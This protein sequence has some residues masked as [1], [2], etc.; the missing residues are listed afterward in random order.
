MKGEFSAKLV[1]YK[2]ESRN[3]GLGLGQMS[4]EALKLVCTDF[5]HKEWC[6]TCHAR[7]L[8][9]QWC[10]WHG[11]SVHLHTGT[12]LKLPSLP[13]SQVYSGAHGRAG[14]STQGRV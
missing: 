10:P 8:K 3:D 9:L 13:N 6:E 12:G 4:I 14:V 2:V 5:S 7:A 1:G 11:G